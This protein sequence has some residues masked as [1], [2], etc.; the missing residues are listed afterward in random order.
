MSLHRAAH[1]NY[2]RKLQQAG[3]GNPNAIP[4][5]PRVCFFDNPDEFDEI[6]ALLKQTVSEFD[7]DMMCLTNCD[8]AKGLQALIEAGAPEGGKNNMAFILGTRVGDP[9]C[10]DQKGESE[11]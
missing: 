3:A 7:L 10:K 5:A 1:A 4:T 2:F 11:A 8:F 6:T 9:N